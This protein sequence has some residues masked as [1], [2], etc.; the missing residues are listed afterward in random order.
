M[1]KAEMLSQVTSYQLHNPRRN[2]THV[3]SCKDLEVASLVLRIPARSP[4]K[5]L[6][7]NPQSGILN[8]YPRSWTEGPPEY[9]FCKSKLTHNILFF[10]FQEWDWNDLMTWYDLV[11]HQNISTFQLNFWENQVLV[12]SLAS[13]WKDGASTDFSS[14]S[15]WRIL[16]SLRAQA[17]VKQV[18]KAKGKAFYCIKR[19]VLA[20]YVDIDL[21]W[22]NLVILRKIDIATEIC[23]FLPTHP[24]AASQ[25]QSGRWE[26]PERSRCLQPPNTE[27]KVA[28]I[29]YCHS[30]AWH[31]LHKSWLS[32]GHVNS[33]YQELE[34]SATLCLK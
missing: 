9:S 14:Q 33:V 27:M 4:W 2:C 7:P 1:V 8:G 13:L 20:R 24:T 10:G 5:P 11:L 16:G 21:I 17:T 19:R 18:A 26:T 32:Q 34:A 29:R 25:Q 6:V 30:I 15:C 12:R 28:I 31:Q 22:F 23:V 3:D